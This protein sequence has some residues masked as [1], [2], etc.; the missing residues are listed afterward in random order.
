MATCWPLTFFTSL[1]DDVWWFV[2]AVLG[3]WWSVIGVFLY[4]R[5][6]LVDKLVYPFGAWVSQKKLKR[7]IIA[8]IGMLALG[9]GLGCIVWNLSQ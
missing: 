3:F 2:V 8:G 4:K 5:R 9:I 6:A 1:N 7:F